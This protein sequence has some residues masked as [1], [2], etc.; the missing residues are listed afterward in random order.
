MQFFGNFDK[1]VCWCPLPPEGRHPSY[2]E[3]WIRPWPGDTLDPTNGVYKCMDAKGYA[4]MLA[5]RRS[6]GDIP[7]VNLRPHRKCLCSSKCNY[8]FF[9]KKACKAN[10]TRWNKIVSISCQNFRNVALL[11]CWHPSPWKVSKCE[12]TT[13]RW[14]WLNASMGAI[15]I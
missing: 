10:I 13:L 12:S 3:S 2:W 11:V 4:A 1:I 5:I 15:M 7:E 6:A 8:Y 9:L 14:L